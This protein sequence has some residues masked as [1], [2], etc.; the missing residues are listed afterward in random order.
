MSEKKLNLDF[1]SRI[2]E[3]ESM[4]SRFSLKWV[5][6]QIIFRGKGF[7]F[8]GYRKYSPDDDASMIDWMATSRSNETLVKKY[9]EE[10]DLKIMF[11][12]DVSDGMVF[13]S[14]EKL[15]CEIAAE[16]AVSMAH[17]IINSGDKIGFGFF[18]NEFKKIILPCGGVK[19]FN[20]FAHEL[21]D[22]ENY[23]GKP[24]NL[25][26]MLDFLI[27]YL[28]ESIN[29]VFL[30]SDFLHLGEDF[31]RNFEIFSKK[32]EVIPILIRDFLDDN[33]PIMD[34][35]FV[36]EDP[37]S[38]EQ[39]IINSAVAK[40]EYEKKTEENNKKLFKIFEDAG[41]RHLGI[42]TSEPFVANLV[43]F[44][45]ERARKKKYVMSRR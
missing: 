9:I 11:I 13:G 7:E 29:A 37:F 32:F 10:R 40:K 4:M 21:S 43:E 42:K 15:K 2:S 16:V 6:Y 1:A 31:P 5:I 18:D 19:R 8:D 24:S 3:L 33:L 26:R 17:L 23:G 14:S 25:D 27:D 35:E 20:I 44:L 30:I 12:V 41:A 28:D 34:S 39:V 36:I 38:G 22:P 45:N